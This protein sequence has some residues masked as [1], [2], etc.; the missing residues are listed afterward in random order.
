M[1]QGSRA[2][3]ADNASITATSGQK[4]LTSALADLQGP[5]DKS[6]ADPEIS[7][8]A[9][10][11]TWL[12]HDPASYVRWIERVGRER[13]RSQKSA[14][15]LAFAVADLSR[16]LRVKDL[17]PFACG[18]A[19]QICLADLVLLE[20]M[21][22]ADVPPSAVGELRAELVPASVDL[23]HRLMRN[24][25]IRRA[26]KTAPFPGAAARPQRL[27]EFTR[28]DLVRPSN[29][30]RDEPVMIIP[31]AGRGTRLRSTIPKGLC[32]VGG[33]PMIEHV[34][35]ASDEAGVRQRVFVLK[36]RAD[37]HKDYLSRY[38]EVVVQ[39]SAEGSGHSVYAGLAALPGQRAPV[40]VSYSDCPFMGN[41]AFRRLMA[42]P[43]GSNEALRIAT[44]SPARTSAGRIARSA[45][46]DIERIDQPRTSEA[47][48][49]E[50]D[51]GLCEVSYGAVFPALGG[52]TNDNIRGEY[53][54]TDVVA[55]VRASHLRVTGVPGPRQ[56]FQSVDVPA[57][58][59]MARLR[60]ATGASTPERLAALAPQVLVFLSA[61]GLRTN[62]GQGTE[63]RADSAHEAERALE[64]VASAR[65][66]VGPLLDLA[67]EQ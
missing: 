53:Q 64:A 6:P 29:L 57:D 18:E 8:L 25:R 32:P 43:M 51:G 37:V 52:I 4:C 65:A 34:I 21:D 58:L 56:D 49:D 35:R 50:A 20:E 54:L 16:A 3:R 28:Q 33:I 27:S 1:S 31:T 66:L 12:S 10:L 17:A 30:A 15:A 48:Q 42:E 39:T 19:L 7:H 60:A 41:G 14:K 38:G 59:I 62:R 11:D 23:V 45:S 22:Q 26:S 67:N 44:Y 36:Y 2:S 46:G 13:L 5:N 61:Y 47:S 24:L 63:S 9:N 55:R 40:L